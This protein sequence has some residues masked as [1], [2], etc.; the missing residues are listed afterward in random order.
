MNKKLIIAC[1]LS[2]MTL[3]AYAND[4]HI[5]N[6]VLNPLNGLETLPYTVNNNAVVRLTDLDYNSACYIITGDTGSSINCVKLGRVGNDVVISNSQSQFTTAS[7]TN[8]N[9]NTQS[10]SQ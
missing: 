8:N 10:Q 4:R 2:L 1:A 5:R 7:V 6:E 9:V 3:G